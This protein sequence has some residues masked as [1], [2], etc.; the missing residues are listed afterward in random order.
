[1]DYCLPED[2]VPRRQATPL[3]PHSLLHMPVQMNRLA[4]A[5]IS[6]RRLGNLQLHLTLGRTAR[7][8]LL[9]YAYDVVCLASYVNFMY[10]SNESFTIFLIYFYQRVQ[11]LKL[12]HQYIFCYA[13]LTRR[14]EFSSGVYNE[15]A[16]TTHHRKV[17][18]LGC[19]Q[20]VVTKMLG[21]HY[22]CLLLE[23]LVEP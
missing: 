13:T 19:C 5:K 10:N 9:C 18:F 22:M 14:D 12:L 16:I 1:M 11:S 21:T 7:G 23:H 8:C 4:L 15:V 3:P 17:H 20:L 6:S 2:L